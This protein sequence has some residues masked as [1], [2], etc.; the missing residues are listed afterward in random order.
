M[1]LDL[2]LTR[3][4]GQ[5]DHLN[6]KKGWY[7]RHRHSVGRECPSAACEVAKKVFRGL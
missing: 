6:R 5:I 4:E 2:S 7:Y 3:G 1:S